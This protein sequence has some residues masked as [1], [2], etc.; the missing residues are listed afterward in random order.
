MR[1]KVTECVGFWH[2]CSRDLLARRLKHRAH[3]WDKLHIIDDY[4]CRIQIF[5]IPARGIP[6]VILVSGRHGAYIGTLGLMEWK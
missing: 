4:A 2:G 5:A 1:R 3:K 6:S